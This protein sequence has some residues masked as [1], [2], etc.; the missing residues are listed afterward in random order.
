MSWVGL[1]TALFKIGGAVLDMLIDRRRISAFQA[2]TIAA[3]LEKQHEKLAQVEEAKLRVLI[4]PA[5]Y[6]RVRAFFRKHN[7]TP[8]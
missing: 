4:D 3:I 2:E 8:S 5:E 7:R 6:E 1:L